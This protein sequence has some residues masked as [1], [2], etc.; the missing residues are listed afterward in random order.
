MTGKDRE[1]VVSEFK[2]NVN[3]TETE[4]EDWLETET[5][6]K[7]GWGKDE[8]GESVGHKSGRY[9]TELLEKSDDDYTEDDIAHMK[10]VNAYCKRHLAQGPE[11]PAKQ[12]DSKW[13]HSLMNWGHDPL[14]D[15]AK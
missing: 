7:V 4:L 9:I 12:E 13:R 1:T 6:Q 14:K 5:S 8:N 2:S 10:R 11:D 3:M 15:N